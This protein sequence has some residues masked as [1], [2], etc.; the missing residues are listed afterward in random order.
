M[1]FVCLFYTLLL[2]YISSV[3]VRFCWIDY[4]DFYA[5]ASNLMY[6]IV[7]EPLGNLFTI[8]IRTT[9]MIGMWMMRMGMEKS[10]QHDLFIPS[11]VWTGHE[12]KNDKH[13][14]KFLFVRN[15]II[16]TPNSN[17]RLKRIN[18]LPSPVRESIFFCSFF[19]RAHIFHIGSMFLMLSHFE[20]VANLINF[21]YVPIFHLFFFLRFFS[22][23]P[24]KTG[25]QNVFWS[26]YFCLD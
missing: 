5:K 12:L 19:F 8:Y 4:I 20:P 16:S 25:E 6:Y 14:D 13:F 15:F 2:V 26:L 3:S 17:I 22:S 18:S 21:L 7:K 10:T 23:M 9:Q 24:T 1:T 11:G